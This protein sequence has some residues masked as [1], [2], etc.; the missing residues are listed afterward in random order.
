MLPD[1]VLLEIFDLRTFFRECG[2]PLIFI[3]RQDIEAWQSLVHVCR[4]W[5]NVVFVSPRRLNLQLFCTPRTP[6]DALDVWPAFP[7]FIADT[8]WVPCPA[9]GLD[10]IVALLEHSDRV[11][12]INFLNVPSSHFL[13]TVL[14]TMQKPF[15][16]LTDL[17]LWSY[18]Y[19]TS[20][21]VPDSFLGGCAPR[22][23]RIS[24][25]HIPYPGLPKLLLSATHLVEL[26]LWSIPDSGFISPETMV[27]VLSA[28]TS[29]ESLHL[30]FLF[31]LSHTDQVTQLE[32]LPPPKRS[33]L[34]VLT[35][36]RFRGVSEYFEDLVSRIDVPQLSTLHITLYEEIEYETQVETQQ[37]VQFIS[38]TPRLK[39]LET[40]CV[41]FGRCAS[42]TLSSQSSDRRE[43]NVEILCEESDRQLLLLARV[44][45]SSL[46]PL[47]TLED[48]HIY[49]D[50][51]SQPDW[52]DNIEVVTWLELLRS[53]TAVRNLYLSKQLAPIIAPILQVLAGG[54]TTEVLPA[55]QNIFLEGLEPSGP[56]Q[57]G[58]EQFVSA[59]QVTGLLIAVAC[60][61]RHDDDEKR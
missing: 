51:D 29:L 35:E 5:R 58:I 41:V 52:E 44:F 53:F 60:W 30:Q 8:H 15:P 13:E 34:P 6:R 45:T 43:L 3:T 49:E 31:L 1:D 24:F 50:Q 20:L 32:H 46:P 18:H 4:R 40:A 38:R 57:E 7:L 9:N 54:R 22:L 59:R 11:S 39:V 33:S 42:V 55:L 23:R 10:N 2:H 28:L 26:Y 27:N 14:E 25:H 61:E 16:E 47:S 56:I 19:L 12:Q 17:V 37:L 36:L 48:L 21:V